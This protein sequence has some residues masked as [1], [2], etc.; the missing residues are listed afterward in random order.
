MVTTDPIKNLRF[1]KESQARKKERIGI[2]DF[3]IIHAGEQSKYRD[4]L[5]K[6]QGEEEYKRKN[7]E[8]MK[9]YRLSKKLIKQ[10]QQTDIRTPSVNILQNA[11]RNKIARN[12]I[13]KAKQD[14]ANE[15]TSLL[16]QQKQLTN[17]NELK[18]KLI[19]GIMVNDMLNS[20][21]PS[22]INTNYPIRPIGRPRLSDE[23]RAKRQLQQQSKPKG[24]VGRP[25]NKT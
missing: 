10:S 11:F 18:S 23:E 21:F 15:L 13:I 8:K 16:N 3:N 25:R 6:Q 5:R 1:V 9:A 19:A 20:V 4:N 12:A 14:K 22:I 2:E 24:K 17:T 7:A